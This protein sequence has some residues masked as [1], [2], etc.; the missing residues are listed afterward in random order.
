VLRVL[1]RVDAVAAAM[2]ATPPNDA[3]DALSR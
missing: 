2:T 1:E 3:T